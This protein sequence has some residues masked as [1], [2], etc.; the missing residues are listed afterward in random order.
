MIYNSIEI[1]CPYC[2]EVN[3]IDAEIS[4]NVSE[5]LISDCEICCRPIEIILKADADGNIFAEV[6]NE[7]G[8]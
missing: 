6:K 5:Q 2:G 4:G 1:F 8:F 3:T 7:E